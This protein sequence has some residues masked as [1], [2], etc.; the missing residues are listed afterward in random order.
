M[1]DASIW[2]LMVSLILLAIGTSLKAVSSDHALKLANDEIARLRKQLDTIQDEKNKFGSN[3]SQTDLAP[4]NKLIPP[5]HDPKIQ[6]KPPQ[7]PPT[8]YIGKPPSWR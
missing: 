6:E 8:Q 7:K 4:E 5:I 2:G 3:A 1:P